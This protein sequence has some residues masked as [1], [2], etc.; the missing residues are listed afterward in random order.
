M[1]ESTSLD[2]INEE[3]LKLQQEFDNNLDKY[4][5][6]VRRLETFV[7]VLNTSKDVNRKD[8]VDIL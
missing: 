6:Q 8:D 7:K 4:E 5:E 1:T 2:Q 3:L